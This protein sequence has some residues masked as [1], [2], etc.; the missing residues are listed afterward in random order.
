MTRPLSLPQK[1]ITALARGAAK[2]GCVAE[3]NIGGIV[4]R[5]V[6][7]AN[8][9]AQGPIDDGTNPATFQTFEEWDAWEKRKNDREAQGHS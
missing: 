9:Q 5:L 8:S 1:Q 3:V 7:A 2:A 4:V 6:P